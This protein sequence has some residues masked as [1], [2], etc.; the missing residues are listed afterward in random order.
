MESANLTDKPR[1]SLHWKILI[2]LIIGATAGLLSNAFLDPATRSWISFFAEISGQ[3]FLRLIF[4]AV[5]PLVFCALTL[6]VAGIGDTRKLGRMG[7]QT[8]LI[9]IVFSTS[10][11]F[12]G[13][14]LANL[15]KP[16]D[17]ITASAKE[18][19]KEKYAADAD[20]TKTQASKA[21]S[22]KD[23]LL[24]VIPRN[25]LQEAVGSLDGSSPGS[26]MLGVMFF[27]IC[28]GIALTAT[29]HSSGPALQVMEGFYEALMAIIRFAMRL[30]PFGVAGL[31]FTMT[32]ALGLGIIKALL[33]Y[34]VV[35]IGGLALQMF[36]V[37]SLA[38]FL[39][40]KRSPAKFFSSISEVLLTAFATSSSNVTLPTSLRVTEEQLKL[41]PGVSKFVLTVGS[42]ANQN[43]TALYE[44]ITVLFI[45]QVFGVELSLSQQLAVVAMA[46]L[47]GIGTAG[48]PG[49]SLPL[50]VLV[51]QTIGLPA[52]GI[53]I[54]M[55]VDRLLDMSR[56][57]VNVAGDIAAATVVDRW[58][59]T[60]SNSTAVAS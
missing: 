10:A 17:Q 52:E 13:L 56:T 29:S 49:G 33:L 30:A 60:S 2:G 34:V 32:S 15:I 21:K 31:A 37:Y 50:V 11:V 18:E 43:G 59:A 55:G 23:A 8:L 24:D 3:I 46:T 28:L 14:T 57:T 48:I 38:L 19:L 41:D 54:I 4:M 22:I 35:V 6:G 20:K 47:A 40:A 53:G 44:G 58:Q 5:V 42:T 39:L 12:I 9:T 27:S 1:L 7:L 25:P 16:G 51:L 26:G 36:G 45:A